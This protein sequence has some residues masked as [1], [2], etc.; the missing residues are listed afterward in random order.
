MDLSIVRDREKLNPN[1]KAEPCWQRIRPGCY[2]GSPCSERWSGDM[3][4]P[5][6]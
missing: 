1:K 5:R 2:L 6:L 3:G 4:C